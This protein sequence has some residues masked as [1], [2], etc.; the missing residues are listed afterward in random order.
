L[1]LEEPA[2]GIEILELKPAVEKRQPKEIKGTP[3]EIAAEIVR[4]LQD[5]AKVIIE[6]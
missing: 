6:R 3:E 4:I 5:E 1:N 2:G